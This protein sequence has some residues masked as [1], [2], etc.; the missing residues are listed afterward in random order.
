VSGFP[1]MKI[2][3]LTRNYPPDSLWG[4]DAVVYHNLARGLTQRGHEVHAICQATGKASESVQDGVFV[5]RVGTNAQRYSIAARL[6]YN[7]RSWARLKEIIR[8][9]GIQLVDTP[10]W[11]AEGFLY[12]LRKQTPLV[13]TA[14]GSTD[15]PVESRN[16]TGMLQLGALL[17]LSRLR[18]MMLRRA[19]RVVAISQDSYEA[20]LR[21]YPVDGKTVAKVPLGIDT[22]KFR[23]GQ[24]SIGREKLGLPEGI[25]VVTYVGRLE[26][27]NGVRLLCQAIPRVAARLPD[28][29]FVFVGRDTNTAPGSG[30]FRRYITNRA[31]DSAHFIEFLSDEELVQ[32]YSASDVCVY[33]ALSSTFGLPMA[34]AM[35]CGKPV[36]ATPVGIAPE[37]EPYASGGL[38]VVAADEPEKLA[39]AIVRYLKAPKACKDRIARSNRELVESRFSIPVWVGRVSDLYAELLAQ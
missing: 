1:A 14:L 15:D 5:H 31:A 27:R 33:P 7:F 22:D 9:R 29:R 26:A 13:V 10:D 36:V 39:E 2:A 16:Y 37:L 30:S 28:T 8:T 32:L 6:D 17:L 38:T 12:S 25:G 20:V 4:G 19:D 23:C 35:A 11:S 21:R 3:F 24:P 18:E 34:E